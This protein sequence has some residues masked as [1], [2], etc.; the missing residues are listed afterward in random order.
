[1]FNHSHITKQFLIYDSRYGIPSSNLHSAG[2][3]RP[4]FWRSKMYSEKKAIMR[5]DSAG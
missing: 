4:G 3:R 5:E 2:M 1:M